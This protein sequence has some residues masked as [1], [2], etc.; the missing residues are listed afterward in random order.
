MISH[1]TRGGQELQSRGRD[2]DGE[3]REDLFRPRPGDSRPLSGRLQRG[4]PSRG[5]GRGGRLQQQQQ[6]QSNNNSN[7]RGGREAERQRDGGMLAADLLREEPARDNDREGRDRSPLGRA[8]AS[9]VSRGRGEDRDRLEAAQLQQTQ[10]TQLRERHQ[11]E[12]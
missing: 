9:A 11:R 6:Q 10:Q 5:R 3:E 12:V 7:F 4:G 2:R 1:C 8:E